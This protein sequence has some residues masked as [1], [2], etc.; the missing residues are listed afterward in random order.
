MA[1]TIGSV[2]FLLGLLFL[3][4]YG[5]S[6]VRKTGI[7]PGEENLAQCSL[8]TNKFDRTMLVERQVGDSR[9]YYF[10]PACIEKLNSELKQKTTTR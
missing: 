5:F 8:C 6:L 10:C 3:I 7:K 2:L 4:Y 9:L 1:L